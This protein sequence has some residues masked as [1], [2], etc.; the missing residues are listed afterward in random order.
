MH[1]SALLEQ[2][3]KKSSHCGL[4]FR[5]WGSGPALVLLHGSAGSWTHWVRNI[6]TLA[7][8]F[9][10][11]AIDLPGFG[12]SPDVPAGVGPDEHLDWVAEAISAA[13]ASDGQ[14]GAGIVGFSYGGAVA[15]AVAARIGPLARSLTL[16]G[17]GGFGEPVG[18]SLPVRKRPADKADVQLLREV[19]AH[20][21]GLW[22]LLAPPAVDDAVLDLHLANL[23]RSRF[24]SRTIGWRPTLLPDLQRAVCPVQILWGD[25]DRL[26]HP[27]IQQRRAL[28]LA[29]RPDM[30]TAVIDDCGHWSQYAQP[31]AINA[32]LLDF[33]ARAATDMAADTAGG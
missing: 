19:T 31:L 26:A 33:H 7:A 5:Q 25:G 23:E 29:A 13:L 22:M 12:D 3:A 2:R 15:A 4:A 11:H 14:R 20:N 10:V 16:I 8:Q 21:L 1:A 30:E 28:C 32:L 9:T 27:D 6:E 18:R 24:D 17:P